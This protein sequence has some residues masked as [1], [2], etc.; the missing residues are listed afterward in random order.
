MRISHEVVSKEDWLAARKELLAREKEFSRLRDE[1]SRQCR[2]L[3]WERVEKDYVFEGPAGKETL[4]ELFEG[5]SQLIVYLSFA[6]IRSA[7]K[8]SRRNT[9]IAVV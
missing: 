7:L 1:L 2:Q 6:I 4:A 9:F 5:R 8:P 3:P